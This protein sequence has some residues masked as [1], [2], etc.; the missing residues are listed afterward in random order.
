MGNPLLTTPP[1]PQQNL[2]S[3]GRTL[4]KQTLQRAE[5]LHNCEEE[6]AWLMECRWLAEDVALRQ[7]LGQITTP[8]QKHKVPATPHPACPTSLPPSLTLAQHP[9]LLAPGPG[10]GLCHHQAVCADLQRRGQELG[11]CWPL[12]WP[13]PQDQAEPVQAAWQ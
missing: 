3:L 7:D 1:A 6:A 8:L 11:T 2:P 9:V 12:T 10:S 13:D 4:L 5:F